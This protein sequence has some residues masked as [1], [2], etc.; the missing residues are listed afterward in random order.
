MDDIRM[1]ANQFPYGRSG[2][3]GGCQD[4]RSRCRQPMDRDTIDQ[5][6]ARESLLMPGEN[7]QLI[8]KIF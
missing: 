2:E 8:S 3:G 1:E 5:L 4:L 6:E 7:M